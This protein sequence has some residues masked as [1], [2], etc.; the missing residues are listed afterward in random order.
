MKVYNIKNKRRWK[1]KEYEHSFKVE[2]ILPYIEYCKKNGYTE[3]GIV[4][5]NRVVYENKNSNHIIARITTE[6]IGDKERIIF[7]CK[8]VGSK[9]KDLNISKES[10]PMELTQETKKIILSMLEVLEFYVAADNLRT[11]YIFQKKGVTFEIDDY[12]RPKTQ[13]V[14]IEGNEETVEKVYSDIL[15]KIN[16]KTK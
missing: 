11:R 10:I 5:Q 2:S 1:M 3:I 4:T 12:I 7:D 8:N 14:A 9:Q 16:N 13:V 6:T 15:S